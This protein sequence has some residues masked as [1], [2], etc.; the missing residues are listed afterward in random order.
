[1]NHG[2]R[3]LA[4]LVA[5]LGI[6]AGAPVSEALLISASDGQLSAEADFTV[7]GSNLIVTLTNTSPY[8]VLIPANV[9]TA[10]FFNLVGVGPLT[11]VSALLSGGSTVYYDPQ[12]APVDG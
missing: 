1:M 7:S 5:L 8:D 12:G 6:L 2:T 3:V 9:L 11:P 4:V 10:L